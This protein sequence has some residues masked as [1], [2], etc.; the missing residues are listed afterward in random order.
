MDNAD[1]DDNFATGGD[2]PWDFGTCI[3]YP[4]LRTDFNGDGQAT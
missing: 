1:G 4:A 3:E 2:D